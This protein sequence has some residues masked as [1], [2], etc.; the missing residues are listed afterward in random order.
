MQ[1]YFYANALNK[2]FVEYKNIKIRLL[3]VKGSFIISVTE[4]V[5]IME[6]VMLHCNEKEH[7]KVLRVH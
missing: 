6:I 3:L 7:G 2:S 5:A 1:G 4:A